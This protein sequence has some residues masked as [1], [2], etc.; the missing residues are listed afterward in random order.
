MS[1]LDKLLSDFPGFFLYIS[2]ISLDNSLIS[3]ISFDVKILN[4][5]SSF[6][7][8]FLNVLNSDLESAKAVLASNC[9]EKFLK[10]L[11]SFFRS[12]YINKL[13][14]QNLKTQKHLLLFSVDLHLQELLVVKAR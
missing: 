4:S 7:V 3:S 5:S 9:N 11:T 8:S 1:S 6:F 12:S 14:Y 2:R 10:S 13:Y